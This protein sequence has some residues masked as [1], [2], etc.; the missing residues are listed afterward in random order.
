MTLE[1]VKV[2]MPTFG[3]F[4]Q[5]VCDNCK[6][7]DWYCPTLCEELE[8]AS[9]IPFDI[10]QER[11]AYHDGDLAKVMKYIRDTKKG[12]HVKHI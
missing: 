10:I 8:K 2:E 9:R 7:N 3:S 11:F 6:A 4:A 12:R 5:L 1:E